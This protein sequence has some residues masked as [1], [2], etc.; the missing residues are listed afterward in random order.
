MDLGLKG[1]I[2]LVTGTASQVGIGKAVCMILAKEGCD[3]ISADINLEGAKQTADAVKALGRK[4]IAL[5]V[6][7]TKAAEIDACVL[8]AIKEMGRIDILVNN[9]GGNTKLGEQFLDSKQEGWEKDMALNLYSAM[10]FSKAVVPGM[11]ER[12]WGK[13]VNFS[14]IVAKLGVAGPGAYSASK[15]A[16]NAFTRGLATSYGPSN[17]NVN[18][19]APGMLKTNFY[20]ALPG[21]VTTQI[22][23]EVAA[24][25]PLKR[26]QSVEDLANAVAFLVSDVSKNIT[27]QVIQV[28]S[29]LVML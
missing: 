26:D 23:S 18:A 28:D 13:I 19:V 16:V 27:G 2:A 25:T 10:N 21:Q 1:K 22:F 15:A 11:A 29:G 24:M 9:A 12:K 17:I 14:S 6:D 4:S 8:A 5:K 20:Q 7:V 3:I